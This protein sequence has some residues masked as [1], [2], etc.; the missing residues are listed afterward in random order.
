M[1]LPGK[2][3]AVPK[4][5][6]GLRD[7]LNT[8]WSRRIRK[9]ICSRKN[10]YFRKKSMKNWIMDT[11]RG[12]SQSWRLP[13]LSIR[14]LRQES[15]ILKVECYMPK[16]IIGMSMKRP[17]HWQLFWCR[18]KRS[19]NSWKNSFPKHRRNWESVWLQSR[20]RQWKMRFRFC[21][22]LLQ[23]GREPEKPQLKKWFFISM[24]S[25]EEVLYYW[26][27]PQAGPADGW[28]SV[29]AV[30]MPAPCIPPW[31]WSVRKWNLNHVIFWKQIWSWWMRC[32]WWIWGWPMSF[33]PG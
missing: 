13:S 12:R 32:P 9:D 30:R 21:L 25:W 15:C 18:R 6:W 2:P 17:K 22:L 28:Q 29:Q 11:K 33:L 14:W 10:Y 19:R 27:L 1:R 24:K 8:V 31:D 20:K 7:V 26:W 4:I 3:A 16:S 23:A 5:P